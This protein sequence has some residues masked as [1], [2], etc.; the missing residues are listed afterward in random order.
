MDMRL[1]DTNTASKSSFGQLAIVNA[2]GHVGEQ[3]E[4]RLAEGQAGVSS[5]FG[6]K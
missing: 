1:G 6:L 3:P 5:Y 2:I 4:L